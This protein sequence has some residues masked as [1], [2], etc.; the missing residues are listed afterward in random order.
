MSLN[1]QAVRQQVRKEQIPHT[2]YHCCSKQEIFCC[3]YLQQVLYLSSVLLLQ[4]VVG[5][6]MCEHICS[7]VGFLLLSLRISRQLCWRDIIL[8]HTSALMV[9]LCVVSHSSP[10]LWTVWFISDTGDHIYITFPTFW[11]VPWATRSSL[12]IFLSHLHATILVGRLWMTYL[13]T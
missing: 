13:E 1:L 9:S 2:F 4:I 10:L 12:W 8:L 7:A 5:F 6:K 11:Q 3:F